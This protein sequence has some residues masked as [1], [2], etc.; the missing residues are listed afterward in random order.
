MI[1]VSQLEHNLSAHQLVGEHLDCILDGNEPTWS[2]NG[3]CYLILLH[4]QLLSQTVTH[5]CLLL[6]VRATLP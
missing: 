4:L 2:R 3:Y 6:I 5:H 1:L